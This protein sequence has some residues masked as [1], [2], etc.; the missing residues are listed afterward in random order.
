MKTTGL[1]VIVDN[2]LTPERSLLEIARAAIRGE[3][4]N[5]QLRAKDL[6][7]AEFKKIAAAIRKETLHIG[8]NLI[9][10]DRLEI[11]L[12]IKADGVHL[13]PNDAP[14]AEARKI[15]GPQAII[16]ATAHGVE[17]ALAAERAGASYVGLGPIFKTNSKEAPAEPIGL[18]ALRDA[19]ARLGIP[20]I[21]I[22]GINRENI[23]EVVE[24]GA[25]GAALLSAIT[26]AKDMI[27]EAR[28]FQNIFS[29]M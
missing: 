23:S 14:I 2:H 21:A 17:E 16:G 24:A 10:N 26:L 4:L 28:F 6:D 11:A 20:V 3:A 5:L 19:K 13:G 1:H 25:D 7:D 9:L 29:E 22:G 27:V 18:G 15:L 8:V 12:E